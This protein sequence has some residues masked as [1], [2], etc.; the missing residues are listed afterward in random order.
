MLTLDAQNRENA[1][2]GLG[3]LRQKG[4]VP[5]ILYGAGNAPHAVA[6]PEA[7]LTKVFGEVGESA[8]FSLRINQNEPRLVLIREI[9]RNPLSSK[10]VHVDFQQVRMDQELQIS[11]PI[12]WLGESPAAK[13]GTGVL[14]KDL[15]DIELKALPQNLPHTV[16]VDISSLADVN[17][18]IQL[19][20]ITLPSQ[21]E[22]LTPP[23]T[24]IAH[25]G[26]LVSEE[27]L[28]AKPEMSIEDIEVV[29]EKK[30]K[31]EEEEAEEKETK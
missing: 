26:A 9:Q 27:E 7:D 14:V 21:I 22:L 4:L 1:G 2:R 18:M 11:V 15:H 28:A 13:E 24:V 3:T 10:P 16:Q 20:D 23:D 12:E 19:K 17:A 8:L 31:E 5:G 29:G 6:V 25:I 30:E